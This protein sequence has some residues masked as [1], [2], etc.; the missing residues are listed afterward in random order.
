M[1]NFY[2]FLYLINIFYPLTKLYSSE[3]EQSILIMFII[4][5]EKL[6]KIHVLLFYNL[7]INIKYKYVT[8]K[9]IDDHVIGLFYF[10]KINE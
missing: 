8:A 1:L 2:I 5:K 3:I 10:Y 4:A 7:N 9:I 6:K